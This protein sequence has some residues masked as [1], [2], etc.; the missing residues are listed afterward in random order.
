MKNAVS[1]VVL[2]DI[3]LTT[4]GKRNRERLELDS[5]SIFETAR[6]AAERLRPDFLFYTGD[7]FE[8]REF[9]LPNLAL[10]SR[11]LQETAVPWFVVMGNHDSRYKTTR[12]SYQTSDFVAAF[13]GH[14]PMDG[15]PYWAYDVPDS[16]F[17]F[18]GLN[19]PRPFTSSGAID[20][21]QLRWLRSELALRE[22]R[23]IIILMHHPAIVFDSVLTT[24]PD[25]SIYYL[26]NHEQVRDV[27]L[28]SRGVKLV[29]SGH[30]HTRRHR[31]IE[32]LHF[33]G[34]PSINSWPNMYTSFA[35]SESKISFEFR[36]ISERAKVEEA[37]A[38]LIH[39]ESTWLKGF[40]DTASL[41][42]YFSATPA[43]RPLTP[44]A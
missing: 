36:Q 26:E 25:L 4:S 39:P 10:A 16:P 3:H 9:G 28:K 20:D 19:T 7:L 11:L 31:E 5:V 15:F 37:R 33:V 22:Q 29:L 38:G 27:L 30:N 23:F 14:G 6:A 13:A 44:R 12:D 2:T 35:V 34:C 17:T 41:T 40:K 8:A 32:G 24:H 18:V 43:S 21:A 42:A 1:F